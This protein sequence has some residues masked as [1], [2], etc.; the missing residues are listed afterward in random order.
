MIE[1]APLPAHSIGGPHQ[2][3]GRDELEAFLAERL[4][5]LPLDAKKV[6][7]VVPDATRSCPLPLLIRIVHHELSGRVASLTVVIALGTH[8]Y[9]EPDEIDRWL[10]AGPAG[11]DATY[12]GLRV[13]NHEWRNPDMIVQVGTLDAEQIHEL[14]GGRMSEPVAVEVNRL[15]AEADASI[16]IGPVFPHEVVGISG[17]NKYFIPGCA[18]HEIIDLSHW[19][20]ALIGVEDI[21]GT[22]GITPVRAIINA[23]SELIPTQRLGICLV[24]KSGTDDVEFVS[25][26]GID[27]AWSQAADV[28]ADSHIVYVDKPFTKVVA[29]MPTRYDDI[30]TAA[31]GCYK[32]RPAMADG[33]EVIIYAPHVTEISE[34][35]PEIHDVGYHCIEYFTKQ[36]ERFKH[37]PKGVLAHSTH[38][39]GSGTYDAGTGRE[40]NRI[41]VTLCTRIPREVCEN[42]NLGYLSPEDIDLPALAADPD[43]F[44]QPNAG[45]ILYRLRET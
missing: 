34:T 26:G 36:W 6:V 19:V 2:T 33:G 45:E 1:P 43:V 25:V 10:G 12:P 41:S 18:T 3:L 22:R 39:R 5:A 27:A 40:V 4:A 7:L 28:A 23:G 16:V 11:L 38:V 30:W 20:G 29:M 14:S 17:G 32:I 24:V 35:H 42:V 21:I 15:V 37:V 13:V 31:K 9:M 8:S 44:V